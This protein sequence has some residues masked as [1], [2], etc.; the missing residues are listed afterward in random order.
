M[1]GSDTGIIVFAMTIATM[2]LPLT[3]LLSQENAIKSV[4]ISALILEGPEFST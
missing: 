2:S 4:R 3:P 1:I